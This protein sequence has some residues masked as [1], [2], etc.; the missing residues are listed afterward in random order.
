[1]TGL[2]GDLGAGV[3]AP[4]PDLVEQEQ[5]LAFLEASG[6][7]EDGRLSRRRV[8]SKWAWSTTS[9]AARQVLVGSVGS[10]NSGEVEGGLGTGQVAEGLGAAYVE[11]LGGSEGLLGRG[12][13][14]DGAV[15][16]EGIGDVE[17]GL[18]AQGPGEVHVLGV[19][20]VAWRGST[21]R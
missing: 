15:E 2:I 21:W 14:G 16:V 1:M 12:T 17:L 5:P 3:G 6:G 9:R 4:A 10:G 13:M 8:A 18:Q 11:G 19:S 7:T 20:M